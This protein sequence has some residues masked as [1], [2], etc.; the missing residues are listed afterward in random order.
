MAEVSGERESNRSRAYRFLR[1]FVLWFVLFYV[2]FFVA[3]VSIVP[4]LVQ[5]IR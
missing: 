2:I 1:A 5:L 4:W 3:Y